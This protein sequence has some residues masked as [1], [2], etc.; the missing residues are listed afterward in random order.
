M[1]FLIRVP[2]RLTAQVLAQHG[3]TAWIATLACWQSVA[4]RKIKTHHIKYPVSLT[5]IRNLKW[6][7]KEIKPRFPITTNMSRPSCRKMTGLTPQTN[8]AS[9]LKSQCAKITHNKIKL[10]RWPKLLKV[11][12][13]H[14]WLS[15]SICHLISPSAF[16]TSS[17]SSPLL[18]TLE[19]VEAP[20]RW[21]F[22]STGA[23]TW[24][25][26]GIC[27]TAASWPAMGMWLS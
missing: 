9:M 16:S 24:K 3:M 13:L 8:T 20:S 22:S 17:S 5:P 23:L 11:L 14:L 26:L 21:W 7:N 25:E 15:P 2:C 1:P 4:W 12:K 10:K 27:L 18:Q 6:V 19:R